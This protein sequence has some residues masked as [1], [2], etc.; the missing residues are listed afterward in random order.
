LVQAQLGDV[1]RV[2]DKGHVLVSMRHMRAGVATDC[3]R[4]GTGDLLA[5]GSPRSLFWHNRNTHL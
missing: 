3:P 1:T 5:H 4:A 2:S